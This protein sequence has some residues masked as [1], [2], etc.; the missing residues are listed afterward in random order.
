LD[1]NAHVANQRNNTALQGNRLS[2]RL[3]DGKVAD[4]FDDVASTTDKI[5]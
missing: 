4:A 3:L 5:F 2:G 1:L